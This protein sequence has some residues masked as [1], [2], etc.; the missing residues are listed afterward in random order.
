MQRQVQVQQQPY[1]AVPS[2]LN[3][4]LPRPG[5]PAY[6]AAHYANQPPAFELYGSGRGPVPAPVPVPMHQPH[7]FAVELPGSMPPSLAPSPVA[8]PVAQRPVSIV[9][10]TVR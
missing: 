3:Q 6:V 4:Y 1:S 10:S 9:S 7:S 8:Q 2:H 5:Q